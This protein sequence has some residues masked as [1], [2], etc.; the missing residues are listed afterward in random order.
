MSRKFVIFWNSIFM[1]WCHNLCSKQSKII[2]NSLFFFLVKCKFLL[3]LSFFPFLLVTYWSSFIIYFISKALY[4]SFCSFLNYSIWSSFHSIHYCFFAVS[5]IFLPYLSSN[6]PGNEKQP[7]P[8]TY[9]LNLGS[10]EYLNFYN[11]YPRI[12][13]KLTLSL[14]SSTY[15]LDL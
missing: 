13:V 6:F 1:Q 7:Y 2:N 4:Y 12:T 5:I 3:F 10:L 9:F 15:Q 14:I 8:L 11:D